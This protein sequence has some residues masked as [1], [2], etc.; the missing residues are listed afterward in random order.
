MSQPPFAL[1]VLAAMP[2]SSGAAFGQNS[3]PPAP[4]GAHSGSTLPAPTGPYR[5]G[6]T[7]YHV[8]TPPDPKGSVARESESMAYVWYPVDQTSAGRGEPYLPSYLTEG[9]VSASVRRLLGN[10][11]CMFEQ[12][13]VDAIEDAP[14]SKAEHRYPLLLFASGLGMT[15][16]MYSAQFEDLASHG[17]VVAAVEYTPAAL[18]VVFHDGRVAQFDAKRWSHFLDQPIE[19]PKERTEWEEREIEEAS[20]SLRAVLDNLARPNK[21]RSQLVGR[22]DVRRIGV[23]GHSFGAM[24]A[25]RAFQQDRRFRAGLAQDGSGPCMVAFATEAS[26]GG[27]AAFGLFFRP[28]SGNDRTDADRLF[29]ALPPGTVR[30]AVTSQSFAHMSFSD[31]PL[32][33][34]GDDPAGRAAAMRNLAIVRAMTLRFFEKNL[35]KAA[36]TIESLPKEG[37]PELTVELSTK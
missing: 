24:V 14:L 31:V 15:G 37:F 27:R 6:R 10:S 11:Y 18:F 1:L 7:T 32:L 19:N 26:R 34:A 5:V 4:V 33:E 35:R 25:L 36:P 23:F 30:A 8:A 3:C 16:F 13:R 17:Y 9:A 21:M 20:A 22:L 12:D 28:R 2:L 29:A